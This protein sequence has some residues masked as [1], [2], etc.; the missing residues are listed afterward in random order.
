MR[1]SVVIAA[2]DEVENVEPLFQRLCSALDDLDAEREVIFVVEGE[3]GTREALL[4]LADDAPWVRVLYQRR[5][6]GL[7]E[8]FRRGFD[9]VSE[10]SDFV[11][12][13]DADLNHQPEEIAALLEPAVN[14]EA[15]VVVGSRF[16]DGSGVEGVPLWK[17]LLS[18]SVNRLM[19]HVFD[20]HVADKTSGFRVY[21]A[22]VLR[23]I[24]HSFSDFAF[25]PE[26]LIKARELGLRTVERPIRFVF[27][28]RGRSKMGFVSNSSSYLRLMARRLDGWGWLVVSLFALGITFRVALAFPAHQTPAEGDSIIAGLTAFEVM[29][30]ESPVF[31]AG[32]R[33]GSLGSH[34][35]AL[36]F[37]IF[38]VSREALLLGPVIVGT[39]MLA[40]WYLFYR[41]AFGRVLAAVA[42]IFI[43]VPAPAFHY[44][45]YM[46]NSYPETLFLCACVL[47]LA[48]RV[49]ES[50]SVW[51]WL[52]LAVAAG[53]G[54]WCSPLTVACS[55]PAF[56]WLAFVRWRDVLRWRCA[57]AVLAGGMLGAAPWILFNLR[58]GFLSLRSSFA[59]RSVRGFDALRDNLDFLVSYKLPVLL[60]STEDRFRPAESAGLVWMEGP[61]LL[62]HATALG[63]FI[64]WAWRRRAEIP[65]G[66]EERWR[67]AVPWLLL[68]VIAT[69][70][71]LNLVSGAG[72]LRGPTVRYVLPIYLAVPAIL[73]VLVRVVATRSRAAAGL[74]AVC[75]LFFHLA[76]AHLPWTE[77]RQNWQRRAEATD[78]LVEFLEEQRV[79]AVFGDYWTVY[80]INFHSRQRIVAVPFQ[81]NHDH[82]K[83]RARLGP[84]ARRWALVVPRQ[85]QARLQRWLA[86]SSY[87]GELVQLEGGYGVFLVAELQP[88]RELLAELRT[89]AESVF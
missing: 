89:T 80:P 24:R 37:W 60:A 34:L 23:R 42:L 59:T 84:E 5:P 8:A 51:R 86:G 11:V 2:Y 22:E 81:K 15:D 53:V 29:R 32:Y 75:V 71:T 76:C 83:Q 79:E 55:A 26:I 73:A 62:L 69:T 21:R 48:V 25:L 28:T 70:A 16:A 46:P 57:A 68:L 20:L 64:V 31:Y 58:Y 61:L 41:L 38:G 78:A 12:T 6:T 63:V 18:G 35:T 65:A 30:G 47:W 67:A 10:D 43:A 33:N 9:A 1:L 74:V 56:L 14:G 7:G 45:T 77:S 40:V 49:A 44:W 85:R 54:W 13:L 3:D 88:P 87:D 66:S 39:A 50:P 36:L 72:A 52:A 82:E 17:R 4:D 19:Q 27:R